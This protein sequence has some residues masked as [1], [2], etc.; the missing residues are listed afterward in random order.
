MEITHDPDWTLDDIRAHLDWQAEQ[1]SKCSG[2]GNPRDE[3]MQTEE[4]APA[5]EAVPVVCWACAARDLAIRD[6]MEQ[7]RGRPLNGWQWGVRQR[8]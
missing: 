4:R 1:E 7:N 6:A 8:G 3:S 2:C 5:Y